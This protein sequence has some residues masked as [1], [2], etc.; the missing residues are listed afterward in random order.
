MI[1]FPSSISESIFIS[2]EVALASSQSDEFNFPICRIWPTFAPTFASSQRGLVILDLFSIIRRF[3]SPGLKQERT[4]SGQD[5][6]KSKVRKAGNEGH[7]KPFK[8]S[9]GWLPQFHTL[10]DRKS[11]RFWGGETVLE[12]FCMIRSLTSWIP[13]MKSY[14]SFLR[15]LFFK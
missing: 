7:L 14:E 15:V 10:I 9:V 12:E 4:F 3:S 1:A 6:E 11:L 13:L 8:H 2:L 5:T